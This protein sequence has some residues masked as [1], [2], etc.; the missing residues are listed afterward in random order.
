[1]RTRTFAPLAALALAA[2]TAPILAATPAAAEPVA[3][4]GLF[5]PPCATAV[6]DE[7]QGYPL[8]MDAFEE[9]TATG[10]TF[11]VRTEENVGN[12]DFRCRLFP[13]GAATPA[14]TDCNADPATNP[15]SGSATYAGLTP[16][17]YTFQTEAAS[18]GGLLGTT[19][20][21]SG[22]VTQFRFEVLETA[23]GG[24]DGIPVTRL[25]FAP[26][27]WHD[28]NFISMD[29]LANEP[30]QRFVCKLD[31]RVIDPCD[32]KSMRVFT[33][34][35]IPIGDHV[36]KVSAV[37]LDGNVDPTPEK[38]KFTVPLM[39]KALSTKGGWKRDV[40]PGYMSNQYLTS[41]KKGATF[42][43]GFSDRRSLA[44]YV[45][46]GPGYGKAAVFIQGKRTG[47]IDL[48]AKK[49]RHRVVVPL[50]RFS[51]K[52]T[53]R[54]QIKLLTGGKPFVIEGIGLSDRRAR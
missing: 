48:S 14:W 54:I 39:A 52:Q 47:T 45:T 25:R 18:Y 12:A 26:E 32:K 9:T 28:A 21:W 6:V 5:E 31:G 13:T 23:P 36:A 44:V 16:G 24:E 11:T 53:G 27:R 41:S 37:D 30:T 35:A 1:M 42:T 50:A 51:T 40:G 49:V 22:R 17:E 33:L 3:C 8:L 38:V 34:F 2:V 7:T 4:D 19:Q 10:G 29:L 46:E 20:T 43:Q 15:D